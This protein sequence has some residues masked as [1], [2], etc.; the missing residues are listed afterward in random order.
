MEEARATAEQLREA[1]ER[2][3]NIFQAT[4]DGLIV[5]DPETG[6][7]V[8]ANPAAYQM[9]GYTREEFLGLPPERWIHP[10]SAP[11]FR[12]FMET[13]LAGR[14]FRGQAWN[15]R[16]DGSTFPVQVHGIGL[17]YR[18]RL[19]TLGVIR[20]ITSEVQE[21]QLLERRVAERTRELTTLLSISRDVASTL[22]L[23]PLLDLILASLAA[24]VPYG[25]AAVFVLEDAEHLRLLAYT[26][27]LPDAVLVRRWSLALAR[28]S[29]EVI[30]RRAPL[31]IPDVWAATDE[32]RAFRETAIDQLGAVPRD[33]ACWM[34]VP[35]LCRDGV[36]GMLTFDAGEPHFYTGRHADLA[37]AIANQ[38]AIA[39]ENARLYEQAQRVAALEERARLAR[40][41]H[42]SVTQALYGATLFAETASKQLALG[43]VERAASY[44]R[45]LRET[46][47][48]AMREMRL[49]VFELRPPVLEREGLAGALQARVAAVEGRIAGLRTSVSVDPGIRLDAPVEEALYRIAQEALNNAFKH[50]RARSIALTLRREGDDVV[51]EVADDGIGFD[52]AQLQHAGGV[53]LHSM[54]ERAAQIGARLEIASTPG[55][56]TRVRVLVPR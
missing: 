33:V 38:A 43:N 40:E 52:P 45:E 2:Y 7:P 20:D 6:A 53:G 44:L 54:A 41:L 21:Q 12:E 36:I 22:E 19:H 32:A 56:G 47:Q 4:S 25:A 48:E 35:M 29:A 51:L 3:R 18:G 23:H 14:T 30:R 49:L 42:D 39:I 5:N 16:K 15:V 28:H 8:E 34:G 26:G 1:E 31:I 24:V 50:A 55:A 46:A 17:Q 37:L 11:L 13:I 10:D 9:L 27:P